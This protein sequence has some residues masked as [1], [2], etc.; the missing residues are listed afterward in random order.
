[1][2]YS[3][4]LFL[5]AIALFVSVAPAQNYRNTHPDDGNGDGRIT[6]SEWRGTAAEFRRLDTNNDGVLSGNEIPAVSSQAPPSNTTV[7]QLDK[8]RS[9]VVEGYEWPYNAQIFH[10]LDT[11]RDSVL[12]SD[13]LRGISGATQRMMQRNGNVRGDDR[14]FSN[15]AGFDDLDTN[16]DGRVSEEEYYQRG[17]EW[18]RKQRFNRWDT[19]RNGVLDRSEWFVAPELLRRL[20]TNRDAKVTWDEFR[21]DSERYNPPYHWR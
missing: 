16:R 8:N 11:N 21:N 13:E 9:G 17:G 5:G 3:A 1:M 15:Y 10:E 14:E 7:S 6:R 4:Y 19:N 20:D 18:Q 12:S 2:R